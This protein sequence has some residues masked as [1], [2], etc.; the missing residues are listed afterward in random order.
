MLCFDV[1]FA[2]MFAYIYAF[3]LYQTRTSL[4]HSKIEFHFKR[5]KNDITSYRY[6]SYIKSN[7]SDIWKTGAWFLKAFGKRI[8]ENHIDELVIPNSTV[9]TRTVCRGCNVC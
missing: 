8:E 6:A 3:I 2:F 7:A 4:E 5:S 9:K 1:C